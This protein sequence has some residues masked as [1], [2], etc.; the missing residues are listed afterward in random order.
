MYARMGKRILVIVSLILSLFCSTWFVYADEEIAAEYLFENN[1]V[2]IYGTCGEGGRDAALYIVR[3]EVNIDDL[4]DDNLPTAIE[5]VVTEKD[6]RFDCTI[7]LM[8]KLD[9][10]MYDVF[11]YFSDGVLS[12]SFE[13]LSDEQ[14]EER[15]KE[16]IFSELKGSENWQMFRCIFLGTDFDGNVIDDNYAIITPD[17][18]YYDKLKEKTAVFREMFK[19]RSTLASFEDI[20]ELFY[21]ISKELFNEE[22]RE[23]SVS[24]GRGGSGGGSAGNSYSVV[25]DEPE[26]ES[27]GTN[28]NDIKNENKI[29]SDMDEHW[30]KKYALL[31]SGGGIIE[32]Y[33]DGTFRPDIDVTR[34]EFTKMIVCLLNIQQTVTTDFVDVSPQDWF[35]PYVGSA[36]AAGIV[37]GTDG[38]FYPDDNITRQDAAVILYRAINKTVSMQ[39]GYVFFNDESKIADY[40]S[41]AIR[42]LAE[43]NIINGVGNNLFEPESFTTRGQAA[44]LICR[45]MDYINAH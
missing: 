43:Q 15:K 27:G 4:S 7:S 16:K 18:T 45:A 9:F 42:A 26:T 10:G 32:G 5:Y 22:N 28:K 34:S 38:K 29:F 23:T 3:S 13:Y 30:A 36:A 8:Q 44:A 21:K 6:G 39:E 33:E 41:H 25:S 31:L 2:H 35:A 19:Q 17:T 40:S 12:T 20:K 11:L 24:S 37:M 14:I 1:S